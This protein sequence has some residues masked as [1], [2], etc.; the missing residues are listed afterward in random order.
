MKQNNTALI[1]AY[2]IA[3]FSLIKLRINYSNAL[4]TYRNKVI[5]SSLG[6]SFKEER[7]DSSKDKY[8]ELLNKL[9]EQNSDT[10]GYLVIPGTKVDYP[11]MYTKGKDFYLRKSFQKL[12]SVAGTLYIDKYNDVNPRDDNLIIYGH[13]MDNGTMFADILKYKNKTFF[14]GHKN[15]IFYTLNGKEEYV[16]VGVFLSKVYTKDDDVFKYYKQYNFNDE[17]KFKYFKDNVFSIRLYD[18]NI[19]IEKDDQ[20]ITLSTCEYTEKNGRFVIIAKK[21]S[22]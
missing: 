17:K 22:K 19:D 13:N 16:I 12:Y 14:I 18:T 21:I 8:A 6:I 11:V 5:I 3:I 20:F 9:Y 1:V 4:I 10:Y 7:L 2:C 15:I